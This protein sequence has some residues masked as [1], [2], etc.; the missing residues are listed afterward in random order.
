M[1]EYIHDFMQQYKGIDNTLPRLSTIGLGSA[2][3][4]FFRTCQVIMSTTTVATSD[5]SWSCLQ[6]PVCKMFQSI[7]P[8]HNLNQSLHGFH[9]GCPVWWNG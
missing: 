6:S 7:A 1:Y 8:L 3:L 2:L 4:A 5:V 9:V